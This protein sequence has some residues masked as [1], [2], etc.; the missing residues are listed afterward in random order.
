MLN[1]F[2]M[3][4]IELR[5]KGN[6]CLMKPTKGAKDGHLCGKGV[7]GN[8]LLCGDVHMQSLIN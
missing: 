1:G 7:C 3:S 4:I 5:F 8:G 2:P 6:P